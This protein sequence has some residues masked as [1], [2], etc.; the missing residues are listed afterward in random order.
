[1]AWPPNNG[2][3]QVFD[4]RSLKDNLITFFKANQADAIAW[5]NTAPGLPAIKK[6]NKSARLTTLFPALT[7]LQTEHSAVFPNDIELIVFSIVLE[8]AI[9]HGNQ[10]TLTDQAAKYAMAL[11][12]MIANVP[13]TTFRQNSIIPITSTLRDMETVFD[14]QGKLKNKFIQISQTKA[15]WVIDAATENN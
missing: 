7:F 13:E 1:M 12:S 14:I 10:D 5:A 11:E 9:A 4:E 6:F 2:H 3:I 8:L 15:S